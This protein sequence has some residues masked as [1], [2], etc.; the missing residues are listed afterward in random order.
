[1][2]KRGVFTV[3]VALKLQANIA[4]KSTYFDFVLVQE[5]FIKY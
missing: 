4:D 3:N 1:M 5:F 2:E